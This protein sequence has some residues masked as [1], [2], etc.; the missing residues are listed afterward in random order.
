MLILTR[1]EGES[2]LIGE[3]VTIKVLD[4]I[5]DQ[6]RVG[7]IAPRDVTIHREEVLPTYPEKTENVEE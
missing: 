6:F 2:L 4:V 3:N 7:I 5:D 1:E